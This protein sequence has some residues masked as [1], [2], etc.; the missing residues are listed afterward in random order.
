MGLALDRL[1]VWN[2]R[3]YPIVP[4][5][6]IRARTGIGLQTFLT[7]RPLAYF[8]SRPCP[9][10]FRGWGQAQVSG[11]ALAA[12]DLDLALAL[13]RQSHN[14]NP[15]TLKLNLELA[16]RPYFT[17]SFAFAFVTSFTGTLIAFGTG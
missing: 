11:R 17:N 6:K 8:P 13:L 9:E 16:Q 2:R 15:E 5:P 7:L 3:I 12:R 14:F 1:L 4:L 10:S